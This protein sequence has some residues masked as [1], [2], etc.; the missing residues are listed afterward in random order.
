MRLYQGEKERKKEEEKS[1]KK[2]KKKGGGG[3]NLDLKKQQPV[4]KRL[5]VLLSLMLSCL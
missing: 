5:D 3:G 1:E 2:K 4:D